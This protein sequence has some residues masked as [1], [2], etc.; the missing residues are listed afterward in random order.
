MP[1]VLCYTISQ[2]ALPKSTLKGIDISKYA[3][4]NS[5][6]EIKSYLEVADAKSLPFDDNSYDVV[7]SITTLHNLELEECIKGIQEVQRVSKKGSFIT[8]DAY[9]NEEE[10]KKNGRLESHSKN[11][12]ARR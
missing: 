11:N 9:R 5:L 1:K 12:D 4:E 7:I 10:K 3:I 8:L 6:P 2:K